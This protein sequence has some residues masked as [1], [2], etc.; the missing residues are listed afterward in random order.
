METHRQSCHVPN[1]WLGTEHLSLAAAFVVC[2]LADTF[3]P[4][5]LPRHVLVLV[6]NAKEKRTG[7]EGR[8]VEV[9]GLW[10]PGLGSQAAGI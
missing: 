5:L 9:C 1:W 4:C 6:Q 7:G 3:C 8:C 10:L 2:V